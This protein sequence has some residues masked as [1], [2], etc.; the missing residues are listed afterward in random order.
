MLA[1]EAPPADVAP[2]TGALLLATEG[3]APVSIGGVRDLET[4]VAEIKSMYVVPHARGRGHGGRL[5][6]RL[7]EIA[8]E[9]GCGAVRLD[10]ALHL[11]AAI[12]LY[13]SRGYREI[14][15]Y[16]EGPNADLWF[17]RALSPRPR[18]APRAGP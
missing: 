10:T 17:E 6:A 12:A 5:L 13:R 4:P 14:P 15:A 16:N 8:A 1:G 9:H 11:D 3:G 7:E 18:Q 2:P